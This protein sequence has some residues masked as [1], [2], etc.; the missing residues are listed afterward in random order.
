MNYR[1]TPKKRVDFPDAGFSRLA[2]LLNQPLVMLFSC[3]NVYL[4]LFLDSYY[5][6]L[7]FPL[8]FIQPSWH[9]LSSIKDAPWS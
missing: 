2:L 7:D 6:A 5:L 4:S 3:A 1:R 8:V 9:T